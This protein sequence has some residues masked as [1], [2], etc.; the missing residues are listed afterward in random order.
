MSTAVKVRAFWAVM[1]NESVTSTVKV[2]EP[3]ASGL[4]ERTP[5]PGRRSTPKGSTPEVMAHV[6]GPTPLE[7]ARVAEYATPFSPTGSDT[8]LMATVGTISMVMSDV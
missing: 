7:V 3:G 4:P 5:V 8:V 1:P 2:V 6:M